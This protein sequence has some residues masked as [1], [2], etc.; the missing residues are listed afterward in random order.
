MNKWIVDSSIFLHPFNCIL[1]APTM[2]GK[3]FM[4]TEIL[5]YKDVLIEPPPN[6]I[7]FCYKSWQPSYEKIKKVT[8]S[9]ELPTTK[10]LVYFFL[11]R[12]F[13]QKES[14]RGTLV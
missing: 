13:F 11:L 10:I 7:I 9:I 12:I 14:F 5:K 6:R 8:P 4:I 1:A 2:G 3:T